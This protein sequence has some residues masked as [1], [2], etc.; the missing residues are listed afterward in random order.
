MFPLKNLA[1]KG[2]MIPC[3]LSLCLLAIL[4]FALLLG[5]KLTNWDRGVLSMD[6]RFNSLAPGKFEWNYR[7]VIFKRILVIEGWSISCEIA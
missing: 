7:F 1:R 6:Q 3:D 4:Y 2:L 5:I